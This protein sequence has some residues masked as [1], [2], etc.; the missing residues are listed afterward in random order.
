MD[1]HNGLAN[2]T[3]ARAKR[4]AMLNCVTHRTLYTYGSTEKIHFAIFWS[5]I[6]LLLLGSTGEP[7]SRIAETGSDTAERAGASAPH[8]LAVSRRSDRGLAFARLRVRSIDRSV[9]RSHIGRTGGANVNYRALFLSV[10]SW[11]PRA[12]IAESKRR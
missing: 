5:G 2:Q 1:R 6:S 4:G 9:G 11:W 3:N 7:I 10:E 8:D 12:V